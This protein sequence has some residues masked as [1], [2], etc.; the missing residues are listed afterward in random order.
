M[1]VFIRVKNEGEKM[2]PAQESFPKRDQGSWESFFPV[3]EE[4]SY[5]KQSPSSLESE[6][7][8]CGMCDCKG[9]CGRSPQELRGPDTLG[10]EPRGGQM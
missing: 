3:L 6:D 5:P 7:P 10:G 8:A 2:T 1:V 4:K 9:S